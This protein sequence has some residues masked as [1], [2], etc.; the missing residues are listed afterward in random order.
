MR[1]GTNANNSDDRHSIYS[2]YSLRMSNLNSLSSFSLANN[3]T[4]TNGLLQHEIPTTVNLTDSDKYKIESCYQSIGSSVYAGS[5]L[6][7]LYSTNL[8]SLIKLLDWKHVVGGVPVWIFNTGH[9]PKRPKGL[10]LVIADKKTGFAMWALNNITFLSDV[11]WSKPGHITFKINANSKPN[12]QT[13]S[14]VGNSSKA[15]K[16]KSSF[17]PM[18]KFRPLTSSLTAAN[19]ASTADSFST[20]PTSVSAANLPYSQNGKM[21]KDNKTSQSLFMALRFYDEFE[22]SKF[23]DFYRVLFVDSNNDDLFNPHYKPSSKTSIIKIFYKKITKNSISSPVAFNHVNSLSIVDEEKLNRSS[24]KLTIN[25]TK[26][27]QLAVSS[28]SSDTQSI[29]SDLTVTS[30]NNSSSLITLKRNKH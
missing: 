3:N 8:E 13:G 21:D 9:N 11:K 22:C 6:V 12:G 25:T 24:S 5:C 23:Y 29:S 4:T 18:A 19:L 28:S 7:E 26:Q 20:M 27:Q 14:S 1:T 2:T 30:H 17:R 15:L 10:S 16:K